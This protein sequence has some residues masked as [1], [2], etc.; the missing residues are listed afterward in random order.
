MLYRARTVLPVRGQPIANGALWVRD[1][2]IHEVGAWPELRRKVHEPVV[3]LGEVLVHPG[4]VN[5]HCHLD[6]TDLAGRIAPPKSFCDWLQS[7]LGARSGWS[8]SEFAASWI[9]GAGQLL[10]TG[11][12]TVVN[13]ESAP[14]MLGDVRPTTP[15]RVWSLVELTGIRRQGDAT[16]IVAS[17]LE[18]LDQVPLGRGGVGLSPHAPYSTQPALLALVA[19]VARCRHWPIAC[20]IAESRDEFEMFQYARGPLYQWLATQRPMDDCGLGSPV[21]HCARQGLLSPRLMVVHANHLGAGDIPLLAESGASVVHCPQSHDYFQHP[22]FPLAELRTAGVNVCLG[23]DSLASTRKLGRRHPTLS[24]AEE[25]HTFMAYHPGVPPAEIL[26]MATHSGARALG[27]GGQLGELSHG[28]WADCA[29]I[30]YDGPLA[31]AEAAAIE[32]RGK[33]AATMIAG[34]WAWLSPAFANQIGVPA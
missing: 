3:D 13:I 7:L 14:E 5:A 34:E 29:V 23:T 12:T 1:G 8:Y 30:P 28:A 33:V 9:R 6:L 24:M 2:R 32:H 16:A 27:L 4:W 11:T 25:F 17:A 22:R 26:M 10:Q 21:A 18:I 31:R 20:H 19:A 15:L